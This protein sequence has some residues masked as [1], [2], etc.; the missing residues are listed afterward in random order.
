[1]SVKK[2]LKKASMNRHRVFLALRKGDTVSMEN[3]NNPST[4]KYPYPDK[5]P[6][7]MTSAEWQEWKIKK[8]K[9]VDT[10]VRVPNSMTQFSDS[11]GMIIW[12]N[13][14]KRVMLQKPYLRD[15]Y[16][17]EVVRFVNK[18][19]EAYKASKEEVNDAK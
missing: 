10:P 2:Q 9:K 5:H 14:G 17:K 16:K 12:L 3:W 8:S 18:S 1:M 4:K 15:E 13:V 6:D 7:E 11:R 19:M